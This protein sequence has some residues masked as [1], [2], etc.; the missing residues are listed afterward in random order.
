MKN[1]IKELL[2]FSKTLKIL[3][4][5]DNKNARVQT[6]KLLSHFFDYI[7]VE[8]DGRSG[9]HRYIDYHDK[10]GKYYDIVISDINMPHMDGIEMALQMIE[11]NKNQNI[12]MIS[13]HDESEKLQ[14]LLDLGIT[15]YIHKPINSEVF[16]KKISKI[17]NLILVKKEQENHLTKIEKLNLELDSLIDSFDTYVI[18]SRTDLKGIITYTSKAYETISGYSEKELLG[19]PHNIVRHP[20]M[21]SSAFK[22]MW[23]TIKA[24]KLWVGDVKNR[25]K[26]GGYYWVHAFVAPYYDKDRQHIGYSAIRIDITA[27]KEVESLN[28]K[29]NNLLN[30]TGEGFLSFDKN[31]NCDSGFSKECLNIFESNN[32]AGLDISGL[33]FEDDLQKK[34]LFRYGIERIIQSDEKQ[35]KEMLLTLLPKEQCIHGRDIQIEYKLLEADNFMIILT[36]ITKTKIL[37]KKIKKQKKIQA[38]L[39]A[40]AMNQDEFI[41]LKLDFEDFLN[42]PPPKPKVLQR[43]LHTFKGIFAQKEMFHV[44]DAIHGLETLIN[45]SDED[46]Y[47]LFSNYNL[48]HIFQKDLKLISEKLGKNFLSTKKSLKIEDSLL[49]NLEKKLNSLYKSIPNNDIIGNIIDDFER[50]RYQSVYS[51]LAGYPLHVKRISERLNKNIYPLEIVGNTEIKVSQKLVPFMKSLIHLFNNSID[52]GIECSET[53]IENEKDEMGSITCFYKKV[54]DKLVLEIGDDGVGLDIEKIVINAIKKDLRT[55]QECEQMSENEKLELIFEDK[56]STKNVATLTSGRGVG[57]SVIKS[58]IQKIGGTI[59]IKNSINQGVKF[60][61]TLSI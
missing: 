38:M 44:V 50:L 24:G 25:K 17:V 43:E 45:S 10:T 31:L 12:L 56:L 1:D 36:D 15:K 6:L 60:V 30:N 54:D 9:L 49:N 16:L 14:S 40:V 41:E 58:E 22:N 39:L 46:I 13:A 61:F 28:Y 5:E 42:N 7:V 51:L 21:P 35:I 32:I 57:M 34:E 18:A 48:Q 20:D 53:R 27:Q 11:L 52:H 33:L 37:E 55:I 2:N 23:D 4:V 59:K 8:K 19:K 3:Y 26:D 47:T 29:I